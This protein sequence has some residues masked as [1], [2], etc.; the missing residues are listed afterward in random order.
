MWESRN[1][2]SLLSRAIGNVPEVEMGMDQMDFLCREAFKI[3]AKSHI[4]L[5][6]INVPGTSDVSRHLFA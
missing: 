1:G 3:S 5:G 4:S 2:I 6:N